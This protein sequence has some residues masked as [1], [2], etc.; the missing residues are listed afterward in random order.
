MTQFENVELIYKQF[1]NLTSEIKEMLENEEYD[2]VIG[3]LKHKDKL[4]KKIIL[5]NKTAK[6]SNEEK[7]KIDVLN[8]RIQE[9]EK[10]ILKELQKH[11]IEVGETLKEARKKVK[12]NSA[13]AKYPTKTQGVII[14]VSE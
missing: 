4:I 11:Q 9:S 6:L 7:E 2:E 12:L 5:V 1:F 3:S 13:Y 14:D 10:K 8:N